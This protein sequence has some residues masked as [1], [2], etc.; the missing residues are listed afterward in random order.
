MKRL[1]S[2]LVIVLLSCTMSFGVI[3][4]ENWDIPCNVAEAND[5]HINGKL[6]SLNGYCPTLN[7][8]WE[9]DK[10]GS[11]N[12]KLDNFSI[13]HWAGD[14]WEFNADF[15][16]D[17]TVENGDVVHFG[18][19]FNVDN[20]NTQLVSRAYWTLDGNKVGD[21]VLLFGFKVFMNAS[22]LRN[23]ARFQN[24]LETTIPITIR[25]L[26]FAV[27]DQEVPL[28]DMYETGLGNP[29]SP[30]GNPI[31]SDLNWVSAPQ[32][33]ITLEQGQHVDFDLENI[34][35]NLQPG[36]FLLFRAYNAERNAAIFGQHE[37]PVSAQ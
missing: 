8:H 35:I 20:C 32:Q 1:F 34:G 14:T 13:K 33:T 10:S 7:Q 12:W 17:G 19:K 23:I 37:E 2:F 21:F 16:T 29:G 3:V 25:Q 36:Q 5:F 6:E 9:Y 11:T 24:D 15:T 26:E 31:Y 30:A 18:L 28:A 4:A 22:S 27:S